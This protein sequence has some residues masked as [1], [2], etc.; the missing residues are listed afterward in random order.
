MSLAEKRHHR[1]RI[2][3]NRRF[4]WGRDLMN[5]T[6]IQQGIVINTPKPCSCLMCGNKRRHSGE[7]RQEK[8]ASYK[9]KDMFDKNNICIIEDL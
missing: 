8:R 3:N 7:T 9:G 6:K 1:A 5:A 2:K 4:Y